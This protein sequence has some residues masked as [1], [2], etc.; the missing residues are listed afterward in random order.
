MEATDLTL[1]IQ[2]HDIPILS[3]STRKGLLFAMHQVLA[4]T[5]VTAK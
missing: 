4:V 5:N 1:N 3:K 2:L